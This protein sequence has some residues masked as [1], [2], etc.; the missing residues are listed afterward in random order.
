M[1]LIIVVTEPISG[2]EIPVHFT[3]SL[4]RG[5]PSTHD[6]PEYPDRVNDLEW[7][8]DIYTAVFNAVIKSDSFRIEGIILEEA[9]QPF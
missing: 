7:N 4:E 9:R 5:C 6:N 2:E 8:F 1:E 3:Y